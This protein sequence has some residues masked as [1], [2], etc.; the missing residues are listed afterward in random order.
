MRTNN[1][2]YQRVSIK[3]DAG[4]VTKIW[5]RIASEPDTPSTSSGQATEPVALDWYPES[6]QQELDSLNE[7]IEAM[8]F[9]PIYRPPWGVGFTTQELVAIARHEGVNPYKYDWWDGMDSTVIKEARQGA[10]KRP[11]LE[12]ITELR[13]QQATLRREIAW[14]EAQTTGTKV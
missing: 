2:T 3:R 6:K 7:Q 14:L 1:S 8:I 4:H 5:K 13:H 9:N 10:F 11:G 12:F